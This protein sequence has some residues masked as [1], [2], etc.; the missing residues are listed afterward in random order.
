MA[1]ENGAALMMIPVVVDDEPFN[2]ACTQEVKAQYNRYCDVG[3]LV[4][5]S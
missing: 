4:S 3:I 1:T 2:K 5:T